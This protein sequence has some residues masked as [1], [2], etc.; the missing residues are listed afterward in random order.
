[1]ENVAPVPPPS[2]PNFHASSILHEAIECVKKV[3][4]EVLQLEINTAVLI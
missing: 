2:P 4:E 1:M 3:E